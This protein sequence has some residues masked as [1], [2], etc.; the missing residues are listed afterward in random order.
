MSA[1][2]TGSTVVVKADADLAPEA[3][4]DGIT[5]GTVLTVQETPSDDIL[6]QMFDLVL[7]ETEDGKRG[8]MVEGDLE[9]K[10][11]G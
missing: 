3:A 4:E 9:A 5:P 8:Y 2:E 1:F 6:A 10:A 7:V 11:D